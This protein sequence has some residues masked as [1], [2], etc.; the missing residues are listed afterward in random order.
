MANSNNYY[1]SSLR[2]KLELYILTFFSSEEITLVNRKKQQNTTLTKRKAYSHL[3]SLT[4]SDK[5]FKLAIT[6]NLFTTW[7]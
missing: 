2:I 5:L 4:P 7:I 6:G 3:G 1:A